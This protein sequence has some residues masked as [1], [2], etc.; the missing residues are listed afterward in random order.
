MSTIRW[1]LTVAFVL[2]LA[3]CAAG[4]IEGKAQPLPAGGYGLTVE[5]VNFTFRPNV[6]TVDADRL[7]TITAVSR[8]IAKQTLIPHHHRMTPPPGATTLAEVRAALDA[9]GVTVPI[10]NP[11]RGRT[12]EFRK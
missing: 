10:T 4:R 2:T 3:G 5:L 12:Y 8:S 11:A 6:I 9:A 7:I 1:T